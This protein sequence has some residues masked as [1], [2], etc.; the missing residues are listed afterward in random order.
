MDG[1]RSPDVLLILRE[2]PVG[3]TELQLLWD[4]GVDLLHHLKRDV[5][6]HL[7]GRQLHQGTHLAIWDEEEEEEG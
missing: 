7:L 5:E 3:D 1:V 6:R 2:A 4:R